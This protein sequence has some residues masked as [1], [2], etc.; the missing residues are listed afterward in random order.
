MLLL[1]PASGR[2]IVGSGNLGYDGYASPGELWHVF[3]YSDDRPQH[4]NEFAAARSFIDGLASRQLLDPPVVELLHTAWGEAT[5]LPEAP[6]V[7]ASDLQQPRSSPHRRNFVTLSPIPSP[8]WSR[9]RHFH[10]AD[11][12]ALQELI[13]TFEPKQ[14]RLLVTDATSADPATIAQ[15]LGG[16]TAD[17]RTRSGER[18]TGGV[19]PRQVGA[20]DPPAP[21]TLLTGSANLSRS[22]LL[23]SSSDRQHRDRRGLPGSREPS[24]SLYAHLQRKPVNDVSIARH[25]LSGEHRRDASRRVPPPGRVVESARRRHR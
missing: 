22:A 8:S 6:T 9:T 14:V 15:T 18:R 12:A 21:E 25:Q 2:L 19:Y 5:W 4:L 11:C 16:G 10:D 7:P 24:T 13:T 3:A 1:G 23:R 20:L 17:H